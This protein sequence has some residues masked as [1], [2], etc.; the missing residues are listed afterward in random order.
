MSSSQQQEQQQSTA[1]TA[2][3]NSN[4]LSITSNG[5]QRQAIEQQFRSLSLGVGQQP[6]GTI[7]SDSFATSI[8]HKRVVATTDLFD[9]S[10]LSTAI[11]MPDG[12]LMRPLSSEDYDKGHL[13]CLAQLTT[14]GEISKQQYLNQFEF[15]KER[16]GEYF[17]VVIEELATRRIVA[18][19]SII[20]ERKFIRQ[21]GRV[22]HVEDIVVHESQRGK[23]FG[24]K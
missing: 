8:E 20:V 15:M 19:G 1:A 11:E 23:N 13:T 7:N 12:Y 14:I 3:N 5:K 10:A 6:N 9:P 17:V 18:S 16:R 4:T 2:S 24:R 22:G 21:C